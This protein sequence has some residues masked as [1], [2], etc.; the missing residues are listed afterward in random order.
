MNRKELK[1]IRESLND[2]ITPDLEKLGFTLVESVTIERER[3]WRYIRKI[4]NNNC[5]I[6]FR[7]SALKTVSVD[8]CTFPGL[9]FNL[10]ELD[11]QAD[12]E[13]KIFGYQY[14]SEEQFREQLRYMKEIILKKGIEKMERIANRGK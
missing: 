4:N 3:I 2:I 12:F 10:T 5:E 11:D 13:T 1:L 14:D 8:F 7:F 6:V 9:Q